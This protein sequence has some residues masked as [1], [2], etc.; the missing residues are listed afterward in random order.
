MTPFKTELYS[1]EPVLLNGGAV[2]ANFP[3]ITL[4]L[5]FAASLAGCSVIELEKRPYT[6]FK[7]QADSVKRRTEAAVKQSIINERREAE[8]F[9]EPKRSER[10]V[11]PDQGRKVREKTAQPSA[12][13]ESVISEA[14]LPPKLVLDAPEAPKGFLPN[15][16]YR[17]LKTGMYLFTWSGL[18]KDDEELR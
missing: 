5:F 7:E 18:I 1:T 9:F 14:A 16:V 6:A 2:K 17:G 12:L 11:R 15:I 3:W 4:M 13:K 10:I 8:A